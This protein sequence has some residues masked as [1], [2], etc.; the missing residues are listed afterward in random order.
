MVRRIAKT[1]NPIKRP[2]G[3]LAPLASEE[4]A[5]EGKAKLKQ[6]ESDLKDNGNRHFRHLVVTTAL[7]GAANAVEFS[8]SD[9]I[10]SQLKIAIAGA[11]LFAFFR[12]NNHFFNAHKDIVEGIVKLDKN[13]KT[14]TNVFNKTSSNAL[15]VALCC[16]IAYA[17]AYEH[18]ELIEEIYLEIKS[19]MGEHFD[20]F[21][22][23]V[24]EGE[25]IEPVSPT[26]SQ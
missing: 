14:P 1:S 22:Y 12:I 20:A 24:G 11:A 13:F 9:V 18:K 25:Q 17:N 8:H 5:A 16:G 10:N 19:Q 2:R 3:K 7:T 26:L 21:H 6:L 23:G 4:F 15:F